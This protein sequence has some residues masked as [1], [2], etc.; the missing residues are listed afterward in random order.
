VGSSNAAN[1]LTER[2]PTSIMAANTIEVI[3]FSVRFMVLDS[4]L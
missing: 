1:A 3:F 4:F 2:Q